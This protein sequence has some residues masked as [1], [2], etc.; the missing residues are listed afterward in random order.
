MAGKKIEE[1]VNK[2][3]R[4]N[5]QKGSKHDGFICHADM[6]RIISLGGG[7][8]M[9]LLDPRDGKT[10]HLQVGSVK[11]DEFFTAILLDEKHGVRVRTE[12]A[13]KGF[14]MPTIPDCVE[15]SVA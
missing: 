13:K 10:H 3:A 14:P 1:A 7:S 4:K 6:E 15:G 9:Y 2:T 5:Q 12:L 11:Y 8:H